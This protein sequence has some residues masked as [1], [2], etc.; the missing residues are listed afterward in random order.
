MFKKE[1]KVMCGEFNWYSKA[2]DGKYAQEVDKFTLFYG[3]RV[4]YW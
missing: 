1:A 3:R 4:F 2:I